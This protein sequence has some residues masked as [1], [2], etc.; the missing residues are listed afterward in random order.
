[1]W[2]P[3]QPFA[4]P[5]EPPSPW[6]RAW[7]LLLAALTAAGMV[8]LSRWNLSPGRIQPGA[9]GPLRSG[10]YRPAPAGR[11]AV[12]PAGGSL[13]GGERRLQQRRSLIVR[14]QRELA[15]L[16]HAGDWHGLASAYAVSCDHSRARR[17][18]RTLP[19]SP[20]VESDIAALLVN[21]PSAQGEALARLDRAL[22]KQPRHSQALWNRGLALA[23]L[24]LP[25]AAASSFR[26]VA[27]AGESGWS[28]DALDRA[29]RLEAGWQKRV[30]AYQRAK[31]AASKIKDGVLPP[32]EVMTSHPDLVRLYFYSALRGAATRE[33]AMRFLPI[34]R[35]ID[36]IQG[37]IRS[38]R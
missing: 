34:A 16:E 9:A 5:R 13:S 32:V 37:G 17:L 27:T 23:K 4:E 33:A 15:R 30:K 22:Q 38:P 3:G 18:L 2:E 11:A 21:Q 26:A 12:L 31:E 35:A 19:T 24:G 20:D 28:R 7:P 10:F 29:A 1:M 8:E 36:E 25:L 6:S 14:G